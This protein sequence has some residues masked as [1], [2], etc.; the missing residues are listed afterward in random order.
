MKKFLYALLCFLLFLNIF[1]V[2]A[3]AVTIENPISEAFKDIPTAI[4]TLSSYIRPLAIFAFLGVTIYGGFTKLT[5]AGD[6][7]KEKKAMEILKAGIIG[8]IIVVL[9]PFIVGIIGAILGVPN[10]L[11]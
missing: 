10:I 9:A 1:L 2:E 8:F 6:A 4:N 11:T 7:E 5:A 3:G